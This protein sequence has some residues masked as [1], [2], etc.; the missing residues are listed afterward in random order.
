MDELEKLFSTD[1][2]TLKN[3]TDHFISELAKGRTFVEIARPLHLANE[4]RC[5]S[6]RGRWQYCMFN[7][8]YLPNHTWSRSN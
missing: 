3:V 2:A 4:T 1:T 8:N 5:R 6:E 7:P